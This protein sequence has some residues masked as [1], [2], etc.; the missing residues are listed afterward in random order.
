MHRLH[1]ALWPC[2]IPNAAAVIGGLIW[3]LSKCSFLGLK[4]ERAR[5]L[6]GW[7]AGGG[8]AWAPPPP[9]PPLLPHRDEHIHTHT[10]THRGVLVTA[11]PDKSQKGLFD[12]LITFVL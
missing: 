2:I 4:S 5:L 10:H 6:P 3:L 12:Y 8:G 7:L 9:P 11:A 1:A